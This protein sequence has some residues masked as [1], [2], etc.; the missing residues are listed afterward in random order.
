M[1]FILQF[2]NVV[3]H[4]V[5]FV[6]IDKSSH[7][8]I[9]LFVLFILNC[10]SCLY[11]ILEITFLLVTSFTNIF[12]HSVGCLFILFMISFAVLKL[13]SLI[14]SHLFIFISITLRYG[15]KEILLWFMSK[16]VLPISSRSFIVAG[17]TFSSVVH[18]EFIFVHGVKKMP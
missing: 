2:V 18:F 9:G 15:S 10:M 14:K 12:S 6:D 5:C 16:C 17:S 13:L 7:F 8:L 11:Y 4:T 3:Y 1:V